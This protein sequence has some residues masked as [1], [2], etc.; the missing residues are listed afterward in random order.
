MP[1]GIVQLHVRVCP[2]GGVEPSVNEVTLPAQIV[3]LVNAATGIAFT[4]TGSFV[5][6]L[7]PAV[8]VTT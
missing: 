5:E 3:L 8:V 6:S 1:P 7:H 2:A 4:V